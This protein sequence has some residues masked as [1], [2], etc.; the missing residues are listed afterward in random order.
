MPTKL[1]IAWAVSIVI[2]HAA[3][4]SGCSGHRCAQ[5]RK[6]QD[7]PAASVSC[8]A[9]L[10]A[11][12]DPA[13]AID[14]AM[15][16]LY[17]GQW[18]EAVQ[19]ASLALHGPASADAH[20]LIGA[21]RVQ[22]QE[23]E[24]AVSQL[25]VAATS[26]A[27]RGDAYAEARDRHQLAGALC[28]LGDYGAALVAEHA[29]RDAAQRAH[30]DRMEVVD[31]IARAE[32]LRGIGDLHGAEHAVEEAL[33]AARAPE[34]RVAAWLERAMLDFDQGNPALARAPLTQALAQEREAARPRAP[35]LEALHLNL[36]YVERK[37]R[38]FPRAFEEMARAKL[39]GTDTM[40]FRLNRGLIYADAGNLQDAADDLAVAEAQKLDGEWAWWVPLQRAHVAARMNDLPTAIAEDRR[41]IEQI[42]AFASRSGALGP[43]MIASHREPHL[44]LVGLLAADR[45]WGDVLEVIAM[46]DGQSLLASS[47]AGPDVM[48]S[49]FA[50]SFR[51]AGPPA[52]AFAPDAANRAL[53][54]WRGRRLVIVVPGGDRA[55]RID[56]D[57]G[58]LS[59]TDV[60][61]ASVLAA[62]ARKLETDPGDAAAGRALGAAMLPPLASGARVALLVIGPMARAPLAALRVADGLAI[63]RYQLMRVPG[64]LP[65]APARRPGRAVI[66]IGDPGGD[67]PAAAAEARKVAERLDGHALVG[68]AATR[69]AFAAA[70]GADVL[71]LAAHTA[72][73]PDGATL[74]LADGPVTVA[75]ASRL[76]PPPRLVVLASCDTAAGRDDAGNGSLANAFLDAGAEAV[77]ATRWSV[78]DAETAE[79]IDAFYAAGGD[80]DPVRALGAAQ[81]ASR[82]PATT[83]AAFEVLAARPVR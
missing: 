14:A 13:R 1:D 48:P 82:L 42:A 29:A 70:A 5:D 27:L 54:A 59:G 30:D 52:R 64:L 51:R 73:R 61:D 24:S 4:S 60:G 22:L 67:L 79:L 37:A 57:D 25:A 62:Q 3:A 53:E 7:W 69:A 56:V 21:A 41:A 38:A 12:Q 50:P 47:D 2:A 43:T 77:V 72:Q 65:R 39:A 74:D 68:A 18:S 55:Y 8:K 36:S 23:S 44:H 49:S 46:M 26:H 10:E 20:Y 80:R 19:L 15:A 76:A 75:D 6:S 71:H 11:T 32:I 33:A 81:L 66:A 28:Q 17:Q 40:S 63:A 45:R 31:E 34:D 9:E 58:K 83:W 35:I 78:G 16:A